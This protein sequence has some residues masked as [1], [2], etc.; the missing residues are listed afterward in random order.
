MFKFSQK[1]DF[2]F[3]VVV[4]TSSFSL[5]SF[6]FSLLKYSIFNSFI[7]ICNFCGLK[8]A[9]KNVQNCFY[10]YQYLSR[11]VFEFLTLKNVSEQHQHTLLSENVSG[12]QKCAKHFSVSRSS[13]NCLLDSNNQNKNKMTNPEPFFFSFSFLILKFYFKQ[14]INN[15]I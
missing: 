14:F 11:N 13:R 8:K 2:F 3:F 15:I 4:D 7:D 6:S 9:R 5:F 10:F 1:N 12:Q